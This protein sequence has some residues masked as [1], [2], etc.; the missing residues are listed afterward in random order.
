M[1]GKVMDAGVPVEL[2]TVSIK[3]VADS[4]VVKATYS[5]ADGGFAFEGLAA[6]RYF[7]EVSFV[8]FANYLSEAFM[9]GSAHPNH[10][11]P[12]IQLQ[13]D[14][15]QLKQVTVVAK[16]A[17]ITRKADRTVVNPDALIANAGSTALEAL[18]RAPGVSV[19]DG[20]D[21]R[22][23]GRS[24]VVVF[25][26]DKPTYLSGSELES[27]LRSIPADNIKQIELMPNPPAK[28]EAAGNAG[29]INIVTKRNKLPG[30]NGN[31]ALAFAKGVNTRSN[32]SLNLN[33]NRSK[34]GLYANLGA[35]HRNF[36]QDLNINRYY[37]NPDGSP[38]SAFS[39]NSYIQPRNQ[40]FNAKLGL[41]LYLSE[42][43]TL[44]FVVKGLSTP[45][46]RQTDN[47][48]AVLSAE[49]DTLQT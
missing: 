36:Y 19:G 5:E 47:H 45:S 1:L 33:L 24:G 38:A 41:D 15:A 12:S 8:G 13:T 25:I 32:N 35:G 2:A 26:D 31:V 29:V 44:G 20:G 30:F 27:Y 17:Y 21:V 39:Q 42:Q 7:M 9:L 3:L 10:E 40:S 18:E 34:Y 6:N 11:M 23:K 48:A 16:Q 49:R 43:S 46:E 28:Y 4:S 37:S 22:L 14:Q